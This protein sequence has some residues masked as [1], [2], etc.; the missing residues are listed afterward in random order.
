V[1]W[2]RLNPLNIQGD[3]YLVLDNALDAS[4]QLLFLAAVPYAH[5]HMSAYTFTRSV[6]TPFGESTA[7]SAPR[8]WVIAGMVWRALVLKERNLT[9]DARTYWTSNRKQAAQL[10]AERCS[11]YGVGQVA[12]RE[13]GYS[14][15]F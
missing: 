14:S 9:G 10:Y 7:I 5:P 3:L 13:I 1:Q 6:L 4:S 15:P 8:D 11:A 12:I 2:Y